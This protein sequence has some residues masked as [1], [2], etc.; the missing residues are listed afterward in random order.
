MMQIIRF[1][2]TSWSPSHNKSLSVDVLVGIGTCWCNTSRCNSSGKDHGPVQC[3]DGDIIGL[4]IQN[5]KVLTNFR[6]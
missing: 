3:N 5:Q 4:V 6:T 2:V 1:S